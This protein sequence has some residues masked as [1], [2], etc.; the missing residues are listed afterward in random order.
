MA[1]GAG[2][3]VAVGYNGKT[4]TSPDG[5]TWT[6]RTNDFG[7]SIIL[8]VTYGAGLFVAVGYDGKTATSPDG[9]TW[10]A[11]TNDF[12]TTTI[13]S[14]AYGAGLFV[15][16][17]YVGKT[18]TSR[19]LM[20]I[21]YAAIAGHNITSGA[22]VKVIAS[23]N[24]DYSTTDF[25]KVFAH[26]SEIMLEALDT[27]VTD[28]RYWRFSVND[29]AN[30][31]GYIQIA[32]LYLGTHLQMPPIRPALDLPLLS[33]TIKEKSISG[34]SYGDRGYIYR[35]PAFFFPLIE[36]SERLAIEEMFEEVEN[37]KPVFLLVWESSLDKVGPLYC[38]LVEPGLKWRKLREGLLWELSLD[39]EEEF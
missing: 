35:A 20:T 31:G 27:G 19:R 25:Q 13:Y 32:R 37:V 1:Y 34:Q 3:F 18:A 23:L 15:A 29:A 5:I 39:F 11:R 16:V 33:T 17:G 12:G 7:T 26:S 8:G 4:A 22:T 6:A 30:P 24:A 10:T 36:Q 28:Y 38:C 14:V 2:L 9:I 21:N